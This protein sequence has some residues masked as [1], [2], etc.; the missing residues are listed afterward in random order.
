MTGNIISNENSKS[1]NISGSEYN[2]KIITDKSKSEYS[3]S[4]NFSESMK[5]KSSKK[6]KKSG[7]HKIRFEKKKIDKYHVHNRNKQNNLEN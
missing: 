7:K 4:L 5:F 2:S 1:E 3:V 6:G